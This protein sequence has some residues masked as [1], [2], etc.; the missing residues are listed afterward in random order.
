M[1]IHGGV[2]GYCGD[3]RV[4]LRQGQSMCFFLWIYAQP[5]EDISDAAELGSL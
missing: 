2:S 4:V 1:A 5:D 3:G